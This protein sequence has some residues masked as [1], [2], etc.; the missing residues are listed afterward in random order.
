MGGNTSLRV[1]HSFGACVS[2]YFICLKF[3]TWNFVWFICFYSVYETMLY[4]LYV[5]C[6]TLCCGICVRWLWNYCLVSHYYHIRNFIMIE[7]SMLR[8]A[9][10]KLI[11]VDAHI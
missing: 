6:G 11:C 5:P 9:S 3:R 2:S 10:F 7:L 1:Y 4:V 8:Y